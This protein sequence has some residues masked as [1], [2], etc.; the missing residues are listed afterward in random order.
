MIVYQDL[1]RP[2]S[3]VNRSRGTRVAGV[4]GVVGVAGVAGEVRFSS[5]TTSSDAIM[6]RSSNTWYQA[7]EQFRV[8]GSLLPQT[9]GI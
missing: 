9:T 4:A 8:Q 3:T 7:D 1:G 6:P 2:V 5:C